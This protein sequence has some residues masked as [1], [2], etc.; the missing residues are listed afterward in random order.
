MLGL[1]HPANDDDGDG[2]S[3]CQSSAEVKTGFNESIYS[4]WQ[5]EDVDMLERLNCPRF[6]A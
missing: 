3:V 2:R 6:T 5:V 4:A 1:M